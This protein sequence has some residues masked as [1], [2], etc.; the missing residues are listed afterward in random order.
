M[1]IFKKSLTMQNNYHLKY[2]I[3]IQF[4]ISLLLFIYLYFKKA[5]CLTELDLSKHRM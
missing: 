2:F 1:K 5:D 3:V 4:E